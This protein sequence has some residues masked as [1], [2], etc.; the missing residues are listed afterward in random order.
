MYHFYSAVSLFKVRLCVSM[1]ATLLHVVHLL[2]CTCL[3]VHW[4]EHVCVCV[5]PRLLCQRLFPFFFSSNIILG[6]GLIILSY[7]R[8]VLSAI[9]LSISLFL[10]H[11]LNL[12]RSLLPSLSLLHPSFLSPSLVCQFSLSLSLSLN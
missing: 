3:H 12:P 6:W 8:P 10:T 7:E 9:H 2:A 11:S 1:S 5:P 4:C